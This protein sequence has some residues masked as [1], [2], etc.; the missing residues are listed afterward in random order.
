MAKTTANIE[1]I[2]GIVKIVTFFNPDNGYFVAKVAVPGKGERTVVGTAPAINVGEQIEA[3]GTLSTSKWGPQ[4]KATSVQLTSPRS[5]E[6][7]EMY[8][9]KSVEG[10]GKGYAKKLVDA[11]G[12]E[13]FFII[14]HHPEKLAAV[15]GIGAKRAELIISSYT[16]QKETREIMV[17]LHECGLTSSRAKKIFEK[18]K[19]KTIAS[20]KE[21]PYLLCR[22]INGI[23]FTTAD[24]AA[25][26]LG[27][28]PDSEYR[29]R[30]GIQYV[31][32][33]A[34]MQGSCGLPVETVREKACELLSVDYALVEHGIGL[35]L[36]AQNMV[37]ATTDGRECLFPKVLYKAEAFIAHTLL[38]HAKRAPFRP[39]RNIPHAVTVAEREM[40]LELEAVQRQAVEVALASQVCVIT[41]G[42]GTG[43]TTITRVLLHALK[44]AGVETILLAAPTGKAARRAEASTGVPAGTIHRLLGHTGQKFKHNESFPLPADALSLDEFSMVDV[45][46]MTA[47]CR[48]L[49]AGTRLIIIGDVDQIPSVGA[50]KV[51]FDII[52]SQ[53]LP[54]VRL[55]KPRRQAESSDIIV[56]AHAVNNG[57]MPRLGWREGSDFCFTEISPRDKDNED[58]K[59]RCRE[60]ILSEILRLVRDMY[61][62]G[63]DPIKDVQVL[64]PMRKGMLGIENL[65]TQLQAFLNP[66]PKVSI[67]GIT[68]R[69]CLGD[70]VMQLRNNYD[71]EVS[72]G[73]V[74]F[75]EEIDVAKR[76]LTIQFEGRLV[77]Y[78]PDEFEELALAYAFTIHKS[79]GSEF[80]VVVMPMDWSY[81]TMLKRNLLYTGITR[82]R[83]L[84]VIL[85]QPE[86]VR[87]TVKNA[88][89]D[90]RYTLLGEFLR[91]GIPLE[92]KGMWDKLAA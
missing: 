65:N 14:E 67:M 81:F 71:K 86:V 33:Q 50:G 75:I 56:N 74:G 91:N 64:A 24:M 61:K 51:L 89:N 46:L 87:F 45:R 6:G 16:A 54:T 57:E 36:S 11:F 8:L 29:L 18:Y 47:L 39:V 84:C 92:F 66:N 17:F 73:D 26:K 83:K 72:N 27:I 41:G 10:I 49:S 43:K 55:L 88:Q 9:H 37:K 2:R 68:N 32:S 79:Q 4:L 22:D 30:A 13:V 90:E 76:V 62:L 85:G 12:E 20:I 35:E 34:E 42:P 19:D 48:A 31:L 58:E 80:P 59:K 53:A 78:G 3:S 82:A 69:W 44:T 60:K 70:K 25:Q 5:N 23:G 63:Y 77:M 21:N 40:N 15:K 28:Q 52:S 1:T 7:I 38:E